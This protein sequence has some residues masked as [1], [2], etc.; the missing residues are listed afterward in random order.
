MNTARGVFCSARAEYW[1]C[2]AMFYIY[3]GKL[4]GSTLNAPG[5]ITVTVLTCGKDIPPILNLYNLSIDNLQSC[6]A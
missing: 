1:Y 5:V 3:N 6:I 2:S 4:I